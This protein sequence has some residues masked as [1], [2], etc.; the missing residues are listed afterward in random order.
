MNPIPALIIGITGAAMSAHHQTYV[1]QVCGEL[2][3]HH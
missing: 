3:T 2:R 1:F